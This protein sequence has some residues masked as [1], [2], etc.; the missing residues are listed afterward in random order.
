MFR[1]K[2]ILYM[3]NIIIFSDVNIKNDKLLCGA[4]MSNVVLRKHDIIGEVGNVPAT[5]I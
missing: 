4:P 3:V 5:G 2:A 1:K